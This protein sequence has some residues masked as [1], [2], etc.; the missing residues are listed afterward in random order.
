MKCNL[1]CEGCYSGDYSQEDEIEL[2]IMDR[3]IA[4]GKDMGIHLILLTGGEPL[5]RRDIFELFEKHGDVSFHIFTNATQI[6][7]TMVDR[8]AQLGN[9]MPAI[10]LEGLQEH[11]DS[12]RG[13]GRFEKDVRVMDFLRE[14]GLFFAVSTTQ[15]RFNTDILTS[16][17]FVDFLVEKGCILMWNFHYIPIGR[18]PDVKMMATPQQRNRMREGLRHFRAT[19]AMFFVDFW[20]DG[21]LTDGCIAGGRKYVHINARGDVEPCVFC[22]FASDNIREKSL[23]EVL[24]SPLFREIRSRQPFS[25]NH[26]KPCM[27]ID[28]PHHGR[29]LALNYAHYFTHPGAEGLFTDLA[30][31]VD[32]YAEEYGEIADTHWDE[33]LGVQEEVEVGGKHA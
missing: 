26:M 21:H 31:Y 15:T 24:T 29:D 10:S 14:A 6:D 13:K 7:A 33:F 9:V 2:E 11:T 12:R 4:E 20:N 16:D 19:K 28:Q 5:L 27:L 32:Q 22:H 18:D 3:V 17:D 1:K 25:V 30:P 23:L 8:F